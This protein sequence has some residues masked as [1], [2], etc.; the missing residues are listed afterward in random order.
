[1]S[2]T[3]S[4]KTSLKLTLICAS[5]KGKNLGITKNRLKF[6]AFLKKP[7]SLSFTTRIEFYDDPGRIYALPISGTAD[8][9]LFTNFSYLRRCQGEYSLVVD[10]DKKEAVCIEE[11]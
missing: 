3:K 4:S 5:W 9:S 1:M 11:E 10:E 6:E 2:S 7:K 8:N